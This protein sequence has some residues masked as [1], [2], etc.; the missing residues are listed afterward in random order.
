M[1]NRLPGHDEELA[2]HPASLADE[3][4]HQLGSGHPDVKGRSVI[5]NEPTEKNCRTKIITLCKN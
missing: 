4:L 5:K 1:C 2:N 3:L